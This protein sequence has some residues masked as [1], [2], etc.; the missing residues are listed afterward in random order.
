MSI[1]VAVVGT[2]FVGVHGLRSV[3]EHPDQE[4]VALVVH[5]PDKVGR[6][7]GELIGL[8]A[9]GILATADL[10]AA[11]ATKPDVV[12]YFNTTHG[13]L[14]AT[15]EEFCTIL[16]SGANIVTTSVGALIHPTSARPDV[17][18]RLNAACAEGGT[19][20]FSTGIDPGVFSDFMPVVL[21]GCGR[22]I[23]GIRIYEMAVYESGAQSDMVAFEQVGFGGP[24]DAV[25]PLVDPAGL[26]SSWGGVLTMI[27][28]QLGLKVDEITISHEM[29]PAPETF[30]FQGR[31]IEKGTV[32]GM[33]FE[34]AAMVGGRNLVSLWHI[35]RARRDFAPDWPQPLRGDSY[36]VVIEGDP[37]LEC[38]FEY[39][40]ETGDNLTGG[41]A[42]TAMRAMNAIPLVLAS[43]PGVKS[44][45]DLPII[46]GR[47]G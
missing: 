3:I 11:L 34:V 10:N 46:T 39:T 47:V 30:P 44:V 23:D 43:E 27:C 45:F 28:E 8:P 19:T 21:S 20:C 24:L 7:A 4:L 33:R 6:D 31:V 40:S 5:N 42:I 2:G 1:R 25:P 18:A 9:T 32:A 17:L 22:R 12:A 36:R 35:T 15:I 29:L 13:R 38:E 26:R 37:R 16:S 41:W 14:K